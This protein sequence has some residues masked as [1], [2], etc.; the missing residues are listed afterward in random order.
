MTTFL[1]LSLRLLP[2][3]SHQMNNLVRWCLDWSLKNTHSYT[4]CMKYISIQIFF[5]YW[6]HINALLNI[7][8]K[9]KTNKHGSILHLIIEEFFLTIKKSCMCMWKY[10]VGNPQLIKRVIGVWS[11]VGYR[12]WWKYDLLIFMTYKYLSIYIWSGNVR[13]WKVDPRHRNVCI[14][15]LHICV[16]SEEPRPDDSQQSKY[17]FHIRAIQDGCIFIPHTP[18][19]QNFAEQHPAWARWAV[20]RG[21]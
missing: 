8:L 14:H 12:Q 20:T 18:N 10:I 6:W 16:G 5:S 19:Y 4:Q 3:W 21:S 13:T 17:I 15:F 2:V 7:T 9:A 1:K 11:A